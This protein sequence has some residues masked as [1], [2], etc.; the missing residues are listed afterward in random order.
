[1]TG[2]P[3]DV[4]VH[5]D[6]SIDDATRARVADAVAALEGVQEVRGSPRARNLLVVYYDPRTASTRSL[7]RAVQSQ[8]FTASL[9]GF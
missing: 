6:G 3:S 2:T 8:G 1:M 5:V 9:V 4:L 7:L